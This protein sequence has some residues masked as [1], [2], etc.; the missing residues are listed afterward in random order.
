M[1][2]RKVETQTPENENPAFENFAKLTKKLLKTD[3]K[4]VEKLAEI[5]KSEIENKSIAKAKSKA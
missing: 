1:K 4:E 3:K 5:S 2:K